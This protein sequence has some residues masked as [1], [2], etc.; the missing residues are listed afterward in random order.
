MRA[1]RHLWD[2][3]HHRVRPELLRA[4]PLQG[5]PGEEAAAAESVN[6]AYWEGGELAAHCGGEGRAERSQAGAH[7][8]KE[9]EVFLY[10]QSSR[11]P[12]SEALAGAG[13]G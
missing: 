3:L 6:E 8:E 4:A 13:T 9:H 7:C 1:P 11:T 12:V 2:G 10:L 5:L